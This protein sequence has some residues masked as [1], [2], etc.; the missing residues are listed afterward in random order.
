MFPVMGIR[1]RRKSRRRKGETESIDNGIF[2]MDA[3]GTVIIWAVTTS[4]VPCLSSG[5]T[6]RLHR[7]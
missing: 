7:D 5:N 1:G 3:K 2:L 4:K 6:C